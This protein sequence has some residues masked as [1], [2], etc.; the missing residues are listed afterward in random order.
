[1]EEQK[2]KTKLNQ[3][4]VIDFLIKSI[5]RTDGYLNYSNTKS[6]VILTLSAA[7]LTLLASNFKCLSEI[8]SEP[9]AFIIFK[10]SA[11]VIF[12]CLI[13]SI[14]LSITAI[15]PSVGKSKGL[16]TFS[17]VDIYSNYDVTSYELA[18]LREMEKINIIKDLSRLHYNL[19]ELILMKYQTQKKSMNCIKIAILASL[20]ILVVYVVK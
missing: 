1:M 8:F 20:L 14:Y 18:C 17:F 6:T 9:C 5:I 7:F 16:N 4:Q 15:T 10:A 2:E 12:I 19:A 11:L 13:V 3:E